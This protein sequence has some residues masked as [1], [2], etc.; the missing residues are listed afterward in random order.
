MNR[1]GVAHE[2]D[3]RTDRH[4]WLCRLINKRSSQFP[5]PRRE[6]D[7]FELLSDLCEKLFSD[8]N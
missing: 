5:E 3:R 6:I 4:N 1:L 8:F 2:C 7:R